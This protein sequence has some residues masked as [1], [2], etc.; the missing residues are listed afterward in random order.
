MIAA[1]STFDFSQRANL[2][3]YPERMEQPC[4]YEDLRDCLRSLSS[5]NRL[6]RTYH[7]TLH[8]LN[9]VYKAVPRQTHPVH[10]V[11]VGCGYGDMLRKILRWSEDRKFP[12]KLTGL[13][14]NPNAIRAAREVTPPGNITYLAGNLYD[15]EPAEGIDIVVSS[16]M[17][18]HMEGAEIVHF[19][20]WME[21]KARLGWFINDLHRQEKPY[22]MFR[23][24]A[25]FTRWH[26]FVKHDGPISIMRSFREE[27]WRALLAAAAVPEAN[28]RLREYW[29][30]RLCVA[31]MR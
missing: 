23:L 12:V 13:D 27:D 26:E 22:R 3:Q 14:I 28:Y 2:D 25:R 17:T 9:G 24:L 20:D 11:D 5:V 4:S 16:Q 6:T 21:S 15:F 31:R 18:H 1:I 10:I 29:P 7:P 30:A 8:W 19:L